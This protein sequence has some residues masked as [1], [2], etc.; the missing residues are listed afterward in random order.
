MGFCVGA[1]SE[2]LLG[3]EAAGELSNAPPG[4]CSPLQLVT[5]DEQDAMLELG[6]KK[7]LMSKI[8]KRQE[9]QLLVHQEEIQVSTIHEF[10]DRQKNNEYG[11]EAARV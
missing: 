9:I 1:R 11:G 5:I 6:K 3:V 8:S 4:V 10:K 2:E 7:L